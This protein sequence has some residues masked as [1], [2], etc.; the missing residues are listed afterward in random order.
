MVDVL[1]AP[2]TPEQVEALNR[3]QQRGDVHAF[4]CLNDHG[5]L[6]RTLL[7]TEQGWICP[8]CDY[9]QNWAH[10]LMLL[11]GREATP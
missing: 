10:S 4:T 9:T 11:F 3:F 8:H 2:W 7:A 5:D 6:G 1:R